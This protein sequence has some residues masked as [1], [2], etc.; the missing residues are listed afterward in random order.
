[1]SISGQGRDGDAAHGGRC[2]GVPKLPVE[3]PG[4]DTAL[5]LISGPRPRV[6]GSN[7][8]HHGLPIDVFMLTRRE[9]RPVQGRP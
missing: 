1:M 6:P 4:R 7:Q 2:V 8:I 5:G 3:A 9:H